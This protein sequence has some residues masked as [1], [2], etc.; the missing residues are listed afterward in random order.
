M[1][2]KM[3]R[4]SITAYLY[5][6]PFMLVYLIFLGY[7]IIYS[8]WISLHRSTIYTDWFN[9]FGDMRFVGFQNYVALIGDPRFWWSLIA[10]FI[11]A[12]ITI[13]TSIG[14]ALVLALILNNKLR[15][16][17]I[18]RSSYFLPNILDLLVIG[19]IWTLLLSPRYGIIDILLNSI[20]ITY[21]SEN[22]ILNN[23]YTC[24]PA[25]GL[26]MVLKG[27]GFGMI[28]FLTSIQNISESVY[29]AADIDG[30]SWWQK[31]RYITIPLVKPIILFMLITGTIASLNAFTEIYAMTNNTGGP[32]FSVFGETVRTASL[33][34][35]YLYSKFADG[36]Y[37][38]AAAISYFILVITVIISII[39]MKVVGKDNT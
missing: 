23:P 24:L 27:A 17:G 18:Y 34:G 3:K 26:A 29:E 19:V 10:S 31:T 14:L 36:F 20:G 21:F 33:S 37:G 25:I 8:L 32:T 2:S 5:I 7:P 16:A 13:P 30:C 12:I 39:N 38:Q 1:A 6:L 15:F 35:Y 11:Y 4:D 22:A 9:V 28:L